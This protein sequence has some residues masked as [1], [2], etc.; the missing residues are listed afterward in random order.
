MQA[1]RTFPI[2][3]LALILG[4]V[5][6]AI[7]CIFFK[8]KEIQ[9]QT[10]YLVSSSGRPLQSVVAGDIITWKRQSPTIKSFTVTVQPGMCEL[11]GQ[12]VPDKKTGML[13]GTAGDDGT[14]VCKVA[15][16]GGKSRLVPPTYVLGFETSVEDSNDIAGSCEGC[17]WAI[18]QDP[19]DQ[20]PSASVQAPA[21][22]PTPQ[23]AKT[24]T[25]PFYQLYCTDAPLVPI[26]IP[27]TL[28]VN[29]WSEPGVTTDWSVQFNGDTPCTTTDPI[30]GYGSCILN[31]ATLKK[32][33]PYQYTATLKSCDPSHAGSMTP[34]GTFTI[35]DDSLALT[36]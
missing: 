10:N 4:V 20:T 23:V 25:Q 30:V 26:V 22:K 32:D 36:K 21:S 12:F 29:Q 7:F 34:S 13:V 31:A 1:Q 17:A 6:G 16:Q 14:L 8:K 11:G 15:D 5:L 2:A 33:Y 18:G 3:V 24:Q 19:G 9:K 28:I 35:H 27:S